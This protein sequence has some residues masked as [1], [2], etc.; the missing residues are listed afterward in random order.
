[1]NEGG[2]QNMPSGGGRDQRKLSLFPRCFP[3]SAC[4]LLFFYS[5]S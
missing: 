5:P 2:T 4:G 1:M 3:L